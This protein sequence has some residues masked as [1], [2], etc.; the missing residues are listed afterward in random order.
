MGDISVYLYEERWTFSCCLRAFREIARYVVGVLE[1]A[2]VRYWLEGGS[3]L[4]AVRYG[5]IISWDYDVDLG[6]YL[7]DVGN[8]E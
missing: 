8:C 7:E 2:G 3:L 6:I 4:G 1:A 5:D